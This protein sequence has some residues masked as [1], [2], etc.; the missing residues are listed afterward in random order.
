VVAPLIC[1]RI[2][3]G[4][5]TRLLLTSASVDAAEAQRLGLFHELVQADLVWA[6]AAEI[7]KQCATGA[8]EAIQL[9]KRLLHEAVG[10]QLETQLA[11]GAIM[12]A[13]SCTT[14]S[15]QEGIAAFLEKRTPD[16]K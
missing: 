9:T 16:W 12:Q 5:A 4:H 15:A 1:H 3:A 13:T 10:E 11:S 14:E 6:R 8:P 2:G 7:A